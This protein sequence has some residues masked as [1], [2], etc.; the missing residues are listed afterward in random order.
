[1]AVNIYKKYFSQ[2]YQNIHFLFL[3]S[4]HEH[5]SEKEKHFFHFYAINKNTLYVF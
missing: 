3:P 1:M 4:K 5:L 2:N